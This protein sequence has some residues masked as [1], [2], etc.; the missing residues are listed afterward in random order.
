MQEC[1]DSVLAGWAYGGEVCRF[2]KLR[3]VERSAGVRLPAGYRAGVI[4]RQGG[5]G[6][7]HGD[8]L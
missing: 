1:R 2:G 5:Y 6:C 8:A 3:S 4:Q 7:A